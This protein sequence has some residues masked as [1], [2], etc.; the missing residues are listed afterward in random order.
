M[1]DNALLLERIR[2]RTRLH[3][4]LLQDVERAVLQEG[5]P[6]EDVLIDV[7][8]D[9]S[10]V[11]RLL[12][13]PEPTRPTRLPTLSAMEQ[14]PDDQTLTDEG[15][16]RPA[17]A[18]VRL[19][20][21]T[22]DDLVARLIDMTPRYEIQEEIARGAMGRILAAW[23][24]HLGRPVAMKVLRKSTLRD[25]DRVRF[26]E[27][28]QVTG[29]LQHPSIVP[30]YELGRVHDQIA[31]V[32]RRIDGQSLK[33]IIAA[34]RR[35]DPAVAKSF[36]RLRLL[37]L[38]H[39][40]CLAVAFAHTRGVVH[41]DLKPSNVMV[42]DFGELALLDWGLCKII[43]DATRS[44]R[45]TSDR[46]RTVHGQIIGTPAYMAPEQA[47][48]LIDQ[49]DA[50]T[51]VY[52]LGAILYHLLTLR[53]PFIGKTNREIVQRV[54]S[55]PLVPLRARAPELNIP[56]ELDN[57]VQRCMARDPAA[58]YP[59]ARA[60]A[61]AVEKWLER[62]DTGDRPSVEDL[63]T[64]GVASIAR[65][66]SLAEDI[67]LVRDAHAS[68]RALVAPED[69]PEH[70]QDVWEAE[71][72]IRALDIEIA[73]AHAR[74]MTLLSRA[75]TLDPEHSEARA[76]L[77]EQIIARHDRAIER[78][79]EAAAAYHRRVLAEFDDG[80]HA[81]LLAGTGSLQIETHPRG[82]EVIVSRCFER[83][84]MLTP[85]SPRELGAAP[86]RLDGLPAGLYSLSA[87]LPGCETL[88][89]T[90]AVMAGQ[91]TRLRLRL[92]TE[93]S[94]PA[95]FVH[96]P[97]GTF[98]IGPPGGQFTAGVEQALPDYLIAALPVTCG[99]YL[100]FLHDVARR[101]PHQLTALIPRSA[102]G[103]R[104]A[105]RA[106]AHGLIALPGADSEFGP[107]DPD[108]P[109]TCIT[110]TASTAYADWLG[111]RDA[112]V[113]RLPSEDEWEKA[114]RGPEGRLWPWG[115]RWEST[116][117]VTP[118]TWHQWRP[119]VVGYMAGDRSPYGV[120]DTAGG[121]REWTSTYELGAH[122]RVAVRGGSYLSGSQGSR[123]LWSRDIVPA[124]RT[125]PD[126]GFRLV[127]AV[128]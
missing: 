54:L 81:A 112:C 92:L 12:G 82:A 10:D 97:A 20:E 59:D 5:R 58:R 15:L 78:G 38:F 7:G 101:E 116:Y 70:K 84:R 33:D 87:T 69:P 14:R 83:S 60:L 21:P 57:I 41:R 45:S 6:P 115:N 127:R 9:A 40:L 71:S 80:Q 48:G 75:V 27:E 16:A 76:L 28:A 56:P 29:Q 108:E 53:P 51:D 32:M 65:Q 23:D 122:A 30:V 31:F 13:D 64:A 118:D 37:N 39:Q 35:G 126:L 109:I 114:A 26:L 74:S 119:P 52:G 113:Y 24:L 124:D 106:D 19:D 103:R 72:R 67:A 22:V 102:D 4:Q 120:H 98:R 117:A 128:S 111:L 123:P 99:Q 49:V 85:A 55:E 34:L 1:A 107:V 68:A 36:G 2:R 91:S 43:S 61:L 18:I 77:C 104:L 11:E 89:T 110:H 100:R 93:G 50:R 44:T 17:T 125:A 3:P 25:L 86:A 42:G 94:V 46:W 90:F 88:M 73:D 63:V 62:P 121:V 47:M 79:D 66:Q 96:V 95:G 105:W 8:F